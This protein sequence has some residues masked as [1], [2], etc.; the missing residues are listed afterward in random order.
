MSH[1]ISKTFVIFFVVWFICLEPC[2]YARN[3][4]SQ[5]IEKVN[6]LTV[7]M[8]IAEENIEKNVL[9][10]KNGYTSASIIYGSY[11]TGPDE[12]GRGHQIPPPHH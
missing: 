3:L 12:S 7:T 8:K 10:R 4:N 2:I 6:P 11:A 5:G 1:L 9:K